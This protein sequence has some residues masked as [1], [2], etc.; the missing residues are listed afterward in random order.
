MFVRILD[1]SWGLVGFGVVWWRAPSWVGGLDKYEH[2][3]PF[4]LH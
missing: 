2:L 3:S 1:F 4:S